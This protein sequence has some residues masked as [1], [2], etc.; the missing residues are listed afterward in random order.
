MRVCYISMLCEDGTR[1]H[2]V[3]AAST[4]GVDDGCWLAARLAESGLGS[5]DLTRLS[6][7]LGDKLPCLADEATGAPLFDMIVLGGTFFGVHDGRPWQLPLRA[8]LLAQRAS[9][10]P[11]LGICGGHQAMAVAAGGRVTRRPG[12]TAAG[13][14]PVTTTAAGAVHPLLAGIAQP[15]FHFGNGDEVST[16]PPDATV[17]A[18]TDDSPA[19][20]LDYGGGWLST[21]FHP[22]A[23]HTMF[24][25]WVD[26]GIIG[27]PEIA[28]REL[29]TGR[30][31]I[32]NFLAWAAAQSQSTT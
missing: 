31:L 13:S 30:A 28:Y 15:A 11:L 18:T 4:E 8:W 2:A 12:G 29:G 17:L 25:H 1:E 23:S 27:A 16:V 24:Q 32:A 7:A 21:Q 26:A 10:T 9:G 22:E 14:L 20:A 6:I 5:V 19:V 3:T